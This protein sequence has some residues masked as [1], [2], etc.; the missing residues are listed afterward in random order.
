MSLN[1]VN[2][3]NNVEK[4]QYLCHLVLEELNQGGRV[5]LTA[6][7]IALLENAVDTN[8]EIA[9]KAACASLYFNKNKILPREASSILNIINE[10]Y[11]FSQEDIIK[12]EALVL[13][14]GNGLSSFR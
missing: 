5:V 8:Q 3:S 14:Y 1:V 7:N 12:G 6:D 4:M 2:G 13:S 10:E 11:S 9:Y